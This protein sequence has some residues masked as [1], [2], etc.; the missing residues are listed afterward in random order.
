MSKDDQLIKINQ[1]S[2]IAPTNITIEQFRQV[3]GEALANLIKIPES[4]LDLENSVQNDLKQL[5][6]ITK[7][8]KKYNV[9]LEESNEL[10]NN[11]LPKNNNKDKDIRR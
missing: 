3:L 11:S 1:P 7:T 6:S 5:K 4:K 8:L 2:D 10:I 9:N